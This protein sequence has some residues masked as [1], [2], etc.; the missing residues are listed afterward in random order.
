MGV[1]L[2]IGVAGL[3]GLGALLRFALDGAIGSRLGGEFPWGTLAVNLS[4][5][6]VLGLLAGAAVEGDALLLAGTAT[7]GGYTTF[8]TWMLETHRLGEDGDRFVLAANVAGSLVAGLLAAFAGHEI[9]R[10]L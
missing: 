8:S 10:L 1:A 9:G 5:S 2:W 7:I 3:G 6:F 4:G